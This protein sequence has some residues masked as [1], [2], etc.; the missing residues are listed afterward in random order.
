MKQL[1]IFDNKITIPGLEYVKDYITHEYEKQLISLVDSNNWNSDLKRRT[2]HYGYKYD[3]T[4][5]SIDES[6]YLGEMPNWL[7]SLCHK[8]HADSIMS[9]KPDQVIINEYLP[10]QG[11]AQHIDCVPCFSDSI[12]S[13]SLAS[14]CMMNFT[15]ADIKHSLYLY[16][17]SLLILK[18]DAR[19][20]WAHGIAQRK[21]DNGIMR[22]RRISL[23][24][25]KV[26]L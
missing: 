10:G 5:R 12:C 11:I 7:V 17:G 20:K 16:P 22:K 21:S 19:Y 24:F 6:Y 1:D 25:R 8:L 13:L 3:Y 15:N 4:A 9:V 26:V 14:G 18:G 23:T 2:Q